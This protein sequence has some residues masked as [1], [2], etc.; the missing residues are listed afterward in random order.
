[1]NTDLIHN[2]PDWRVQEYRVGEL[3][4]NPILPEDVA[5]TV[6]FLLSDQSKHYTGAVFDIN[7]GLYRR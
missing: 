4:K 7:N 6:S 3:L 1:V 5:D 2:V